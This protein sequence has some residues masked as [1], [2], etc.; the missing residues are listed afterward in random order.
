MDCR[1]LGK[2]A[3]FING[4]NLGR[5]WYEGPVLYL[6]IPAPLIKRGKNE[7]IIFE[8]EGNVNETLA[9]SDRPV[10]G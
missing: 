1:G 6:Y 9:F 8:T 2:G 4:F 5:Y 3:A 7:I 10:Y